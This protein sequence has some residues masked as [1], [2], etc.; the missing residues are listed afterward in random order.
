MEK[1]G[2]KLNLAGSVSLKMLQ[3]KKQEYGANI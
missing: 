3:L 2:Q 1:Q